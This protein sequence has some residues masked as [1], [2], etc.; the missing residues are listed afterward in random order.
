MLRAFWQP[1]L[2][3]ALQPSFAAWCWQQGCA[4]P[5]TIAHG[6]GGSSCSAAPFYSLVGGKRPC[7][8]K[9][10]AAQASCHCLNCSTIYV[11]VLFC[12][13]DSSQ[14]R[15]T[16]GKVLYIRVSKPMQWNLFTD[17]NTGI[18]MKTC[19]PPVS[20]LS[21]IM[22][23]GPRWWGRF[24]ASLR[25]HL[26]NTWQ[27]LCWLMTSATKVCWS[28]NTLLAEKANALFEN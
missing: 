3:A 12:L 20:S 28:I 17:A 25:E 2:G 1:Q 18:M 14:Q 16:C 10:A 11:L 5:H 19:S 13:K 27:K 15:C 6:H 9:R 22:K 23:G 7:F 26:G 4:E 24:T 8:L 21:S